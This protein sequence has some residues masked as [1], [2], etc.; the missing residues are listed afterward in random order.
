MRLVKSKSGIDF[1]ID[2]GTFIEAEKNS[3]TKKGLCVLRI[4]ENEIMNNTNYAFSAQ[5]DSKND[6]DNFAKRITE[7]K[8]LNLSGDAF[9]Y[10]QNFY[11]LA[12]M[13]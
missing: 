4:N 13:I 10:G 6:W 2:F 12:V 5:I 9:G 7:E 8:V 1:L 3:L 11:L